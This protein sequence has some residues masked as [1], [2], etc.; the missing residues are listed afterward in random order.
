M[1]F[2]KCHKWFAREQIILSF[3]PKLFIHVK[4]VCRSFASSKLLMLTELVLSTSF[5]IRLVAQVESMFLEICP[6]K[7]TVIV[8]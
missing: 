4:I 5:E 6:S 1:L 7:L 8:F 2:K 3:I